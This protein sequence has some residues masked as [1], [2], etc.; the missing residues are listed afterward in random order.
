MYWAIGYQENV[1]FKEMVLFTLFM[2]TAVKTLMLIGNVN[3]YLPIK[4]VEWKF[5]AFVLYITRSFN[6]SANKAHTQAPY[7][8]VYTFAYRKF[9]IRVNLMKIGKLVYHYLF[10][11][12]LKFH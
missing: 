6:S 10:Q 11:N 8:A 7:F 12:K 5:L 9:S 3:S 2:S 1:L 4:G